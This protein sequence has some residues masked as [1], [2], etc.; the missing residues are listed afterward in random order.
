VQLKPS[1]HLLFAKKRGVL[2]FTATSAKMLTVHN[3]RIADF[4]TPG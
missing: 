4:P 2:R 3:A 1:L